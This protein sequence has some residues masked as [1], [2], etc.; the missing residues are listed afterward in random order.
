M[1]IHKT[2][3]TISLFFFQGLFQ[4]LYNLAIIIVYKMKSIWYISLTLADHYVNIII[5]IVF[6]RYCRR[7]IMKFKLF[8]LAAICFIFSSCSVFSGG[9]AKSVLVSKTTVGDADADS[10][11]DPVTPDSAGDTLS[12]DTSDNDSS[13]SE[14][15][16]DSS[17]DAS[18]KD[19]SS[20]EE[21]DDSSE[22]S[23]DSSQTAAEAATY[24]TRKQTSATVPSQTAAPEVTTAEKTTAEVTV[25][26]P[27]TT[28]SEVNTT[29][30][31]PVTT[32]GRQTAHT[33][34]KTTAGEKQTTPS[35]TAA[36]SEGII[37]IPPEII[38]T[39]TTDTDDD[40]WS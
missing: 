31:P 33:A 26:T 34:K 4:K 11:A 7:V 40:D 1:L 32:T 29:A 38:V 27:Q 24:T 22:D 20:E 39:G 19:S 37:D 15:S 17:D 13:M 10:G 25:T 14:D 5:V 6:L 23:S 30:A 12:S 36:S 2:Y 18:S 16:D 8:V 9:E 3:Y 35:V 21:D 28:A